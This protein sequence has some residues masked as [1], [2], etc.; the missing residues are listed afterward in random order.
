MPADAAVQESGTQATHALEEPV[1]VLRQRG[2]P[3]TEVW[4]L[5]QQTLGTEAAQTV[6]DMET[7]KLQWERR[8]RDFVQQKT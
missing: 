7:Q 4:A 2:A 8:Y 3:E 1:A 5:R 6:V